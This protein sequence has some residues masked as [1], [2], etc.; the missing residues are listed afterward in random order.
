MDAIIIIIEG[1]QVE[2]ENDEF[3]RFFFSHEPNI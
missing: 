2:E 3:S 1:A